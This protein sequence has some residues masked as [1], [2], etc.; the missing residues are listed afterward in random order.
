VTAYWATEDLPAY[1][2][3]SDQPPP[4]DRRLTDLWGQGLTAT[5]TDTMTTVQ[6]ASQEYL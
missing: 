2:W 5:A 6:L 1:A 3:D 4:D